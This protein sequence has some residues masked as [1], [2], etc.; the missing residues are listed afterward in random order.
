MSDDILLILESHLPIHG[1]DTNVKN[2]EWYPED[3]NVYKK[4]IQY[5]SKT[6]PKTEAKTEK[7]KIE[8]NVE[9]QTEN[10]TEANIESKI[11]HFKTNENVIVNMSEKLSQ[12]IRKRSSKATKEIQQS[13]LTIIMNETSTLEYSKDYVKSKLIETISSKEYIKVFGSKKSAEI[14]TGIVNDKW[15]KSTALFIS[16]LLDKTLLLNNT[17]I[18]Y[19]SEKNNGI[20]K[21]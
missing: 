11:E 20:I 15:N 14:M 1:D 17:E 16:F 12:P 2:I 10:K 3:F 8:S 18:I 5:I 9:S 7:I 13:P 4:H 19:N 6:E 21:V